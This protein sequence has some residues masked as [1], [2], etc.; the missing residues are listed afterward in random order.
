MWKCRQCGYLGAAILSINGITFDKPKCP[1]CLKL[2]IEA[3]V[4]TLERADLT[5]VS[6]VELAQME[7]I[8]APAKA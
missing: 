4:A 2:W 7:G 1:N 5:P 6:A 8:N 3:H